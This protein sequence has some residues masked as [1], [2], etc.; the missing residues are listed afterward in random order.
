MRSSTKRRVVRVLI[1]LVLTLGYVLLRDYADRAR[2]MEAVLGLSHGDPAWHA[3]VT[4]GVLA[5][6]VAAYAVVGGTLLAWP[7][8]E[9]L[10][11]REA[12]PPGGVDTAPS[13]G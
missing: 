11:A 10:R 6:R 12:R 3:F 2:S 13:D 8:E 4:L 7:L 1:P 5:L 9:L